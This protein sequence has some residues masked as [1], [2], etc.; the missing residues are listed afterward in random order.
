MNRGRLFF[1]RQNTAPA[2]DWKSKQFRRMP[3][4]SLNGVPDIIVVKG[5]N[6]IFLE[7]KRKNT[8]QSQEQKE[9]EQYCK[10]QGAEYY[11][12]RSLDDVLP[13][14]LESVNRKLVGNL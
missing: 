1:W 7:V 3:K 8:K 5:P 4:F 11:V 14:G 9:F 2:F 13:L 12:V 6:V 10:D